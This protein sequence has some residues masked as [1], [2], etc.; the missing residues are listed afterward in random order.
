MTSEIARTIATCSIWLA[1]AMILTFG[2][3]FKI[4]GDS[5]VVLAIMV[6]VPVV[7]CGAAAFSTR[8]I[9]TAPVSEIP[10]KPATTSPPVIPD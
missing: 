9:W 3:I 1:A 10:R 2:G 6:G 7:V 5:A 4:S 8:A